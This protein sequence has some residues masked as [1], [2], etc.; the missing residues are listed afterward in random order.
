VTEEHAVRVKCYDGK[1]DDFM[2]RD[3]E[4][5]HFEALDECAW[6]ATVVLASGEIWQLNFGARNERAKGYARADWVEGPR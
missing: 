1:L 5:V 6:Y 2:A 4:M 3:V